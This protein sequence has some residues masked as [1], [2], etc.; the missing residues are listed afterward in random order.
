M[1]NQKQLAV[2]LGLLVTM[3]CQSALTFASPLVPSSD[4]DARQLEKNWVPKTEKKPALE[5]QT[6][7]PLPLP[8]DYSFYVTRIHFEGVTSPDEQF[9]LQNLAAKYKKRNVTMKDLQQLSGEV[10]NYYYGKGLLLA[11]AILPPQTITGGEVTMKVFTGH[12]GNV[13]LQNNSRFRTGRLEDYVHAL[14]PGELIKQRK[15][16]DVVNN[17]DNLHGLKAHG[18]LMPGKEPGTADLT[19]QVQ[20]RKVST[21]SVYV[22]N[23]GNKFTGW[24]HLGFNTEFDNLSRIGDM[25]TFGAS[26]TNKHTYNFNVNYEIPVGSRGSLMGIGLSRLNYGYQFNDFINAQGKTTT[27][28]LYGKTP[29]LNDGWRLMNLVYGFDHRNIR[30]E[31][32]L[33]N[34]SATT[35]KT[36]NAGYVGFAGHYNDPHY[37]NGYNLFYR[38]GFV[39][40]EDS[41][42]D[43][44]HFGRFNLDM[45]H[46]Q[47]LAPHWDFR[48][49]LHAQATNQ[50][51][52]SSE[53]MSLGGMSGV[54]A[55]AQGEATGDKG[56]QY[57]TELVY[58]TGVTGLSVSTYFDSGRIVQNDFNTGRTLSGYG[59]GLEYLKPLSW[60]ARLDYA[61]KI[62]GQYDFSERSNNQDRFWF[63]VY[64]LF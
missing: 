13:T 41:P 30:D 61:R 17:I 20:D 26:T 22:D 63:Q 14:K 18:V 9:D 45:I 36:S 56:I 39:N 15:V 59:F 25:L 3:G 47:H 29:I 2:V 33:G 11:E 42:S 49:N 48:I 64:K 10:H 40:Y 62:N 32:I 1:S 4:T 23:A 19:I 27:Y 12:L 44:Q 50:S 21:S 37:Y 58:K 28:S 57:T 55:Y 35:K 53:Q 38:N 24:Y 51:L 7:T 31:Y 54:R 6:P 8:K 43:K 5:N 46:V 60:Y 52:D 16:N 34:L